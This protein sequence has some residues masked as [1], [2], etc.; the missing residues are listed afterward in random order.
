MPGNGN[1][2]GGNGG[3]LSMAG[4]VDLRAP[5]SSWRVA[6]VRKILLPTRRAG[7]LAS[8]PD[9]RLALVQMDIVSTLRPG[10]VQGSIAQFGGSAALSPSTWG[11]L[12]LGTVSASYPQ[13]LYPA[14]EGHEFVCEAPFGEAPQFSEERAALSSSA[15][16][17][18]RAP[19]SK[20]VQA[21]AW[22]PFA[23][24]PALFVVAG[25]GRLHVVVARTVALRLGAAGEVGETE[26]VSSYREEKWRKLESEILLGMEAR[27]V[28]KWR[29][30]RFAPG[31]D[32][33]TG[34]EG[35]V[36]RAKR[37]TSA[38]SRTVEE[39]VDELGDDADLEPAKRVLPAAGDDAVADGADALNDATVNAFVGSSSEGRP[40]DVFPPHDVQSLDS[41]LLFVTLPSG[42]KQ[43]VSVTALATMI[44]ASCFLSVDDF[45][46]AP[47]YACKLSEEWTAAVR[48]LALP[49]SRGNKARDTAFLAIAKMNL[50]EIYRVSAVWSENVVHLEHGKVWGPEKNLPGAITAIDCWW[51]ITAGTESSSRKISVRV[52][53]CAEN[54]IAML[55]WNFRAAGEATLSAESP[56]SGGWT[57]KLR[58]NDFAITRSCD[59]FRGNWS[60]PVYAVFEK[61]MQHLQVVNSVRFLQD[62]RLVSCSEDGSVVSWVL[63]FAMGERDTE[64]E[65][66]TM[67]REDYLL[68][69]DFRHPVFGLAML[70]LGLCVALHVS[71]P[72]EDEAYAKTNTTLLMKYKATARLS[73]VMIMAPVWRDVDQ[74]EC[75]ISRAVGSIISGAHYGGGVVADDLRKML[76]QQSREVR[77]EALV[78][79]RKLVE[80]L[81][82]RGVDLKRDDMVLC[83]RVVRCL[84]ATIVQLQ[85]GLEVMEGREEAQDLLEEMTE[86][87]VYMRCCAVLEAATGAPEKPEDEQAADC[88]LEHM[89]RLERSSI[90]AICSYV[91]AARGNGA[92]KSA[93]YA[94]RL[95]TAFASACKRVNSAGNLLACPVCACDE[96]LTVAQA[97]IDVSGCNEMVVRC[98]QGE[99][100]WKRCALTMLPC[101]NAIPLCCVGCRDTIACPF[102][103]REDF[104][105]GAGTAVGGSARPFS[106][107]AKHA[108][109]PLCSCSYAATD[110]IGF[111]APP[112]STGQ[113]F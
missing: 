23:E 44:G 68:E 94:E 84:A 73:R 39:D 25:D 86:L 33:G 19:C 16:E 80:A 74:V 15:A 52:A 47:T 37:R 32:E 111:Y 9:G 60:Q 28:G 78:H 30:A 11:S 113:V 99:D 63:K 93:S 34:G 72:C 10:G 64:P 55:S 75:L 97:A 112:E 104:M 108:S 35:P 85:K 7:G 20:D 29:S 54:G 107:L 57:G 8:A 5:V 58:G 59:M 14:A 45:E 26:M 100:E 83:G 101:T 49:A 21:V 36:I 31:A 96:D 1:G 91:L 87:L 46:S 90:Y 22:A 103:S 43:R 88:K 51:D 27:R 98:G 109:C 17:V 6:G 24:R 81:K 89:T 70:K 71:V 13:N 62:G 56:D 2:G 4:A 18:G 38:S 95:A 67:H 76:E 65:L 77:Q 61:S 106:W 40:P 105:R 50:L 48:W 79:I 53:S 92:D 69:G 41:V 82:T 12:V 102:L 42:A 110:G 66:Q 3:L